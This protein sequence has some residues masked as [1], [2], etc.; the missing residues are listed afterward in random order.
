[1]DILE[2]SSG[3][4]GGPEF[5]STHP[6]PANRKE[7]I[8]KILDNLPEAYRNQNVG[9]REAVER[10]ETKPRFDFDPNPNLDLDR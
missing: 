4:A 1:M 7:Y 3:G 10:R 2:K 8:Q 9:G 5:M 6:R